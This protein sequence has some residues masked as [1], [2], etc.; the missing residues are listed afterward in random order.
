MGLRAARERQRFALRAHVHAVDEV[1]V[2]LDR[3]LDEPL[4]V[5]EG[6]VQRE[7]AQR[8]RVVLGQ[9]LALAGDAFFDEVLHRAQVL[10]GSL[11]ARH[12][13]DGERG[14]PDD[15]GYQQERA[16]ELVPKALDGAALRSSLGGSIH[17]LLDDV[18]DL[19]ER[20]L[21]QS[22]AL[23]HLREVDGGGGGQRQV[24]LVIEQS[25]ESRRLRGRRCDWRFA[26]PAPCD[27]AIRRRCRRT[28]RPPRA[29]LRRRSPA[30]TGAR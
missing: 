21:T 9:D 19:F 15:A 16:D 5:E 24:H 12:P 26:L 7:A 13:D 22:E 18:I 2:V 27:Q 3:A 6:V 25:A 10:G 20:V 8:E 17:A 29:T 4:H 11:R 1:P 14:E 30:C 23:A 28:S